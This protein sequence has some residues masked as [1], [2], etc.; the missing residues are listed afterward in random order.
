[1]INSSTIARCAKSS[2]LSA[3]ITSL[4]I[5]AMIV[6]RTGLDLLFGVRQHFNWIPALEMS[7]VVG[8]LWFSVFFVWS[9]VAA[10]GAEPVAEILEEETRE[11]ELTA[12]PL[13]GFV[14]MEYYWLI[15]NRTCVVFIAPEGLFGWRAQGMVTNVDR[16]YY[17]PYQQML[18]DTE[19]LRAREAIKKLSQLRGGFF[20]ERSKIT[21]VAAYDRQKWGMGG[22]LHSGR[23]LVRLNSGQSREFILLGSVDREDVRN[24]IVQVLGTQVTSVV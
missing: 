15:L 11:Q 7:F 14:A 4:S 20:L 22:I 6:L 24:R 10:V 18:E 2:A 3:A 13:S 12:R 23:I 21:S 17:E 16:N 1:M 8:A 9:L 5:L 19:F